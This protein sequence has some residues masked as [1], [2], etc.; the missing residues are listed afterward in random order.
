MDIDPDMNYFNT[1]I[2]NN[3]TYFLPDEFNDIDRARR[4]PYTQ[5]RFSLMHMNIV[6]VCCVTSMIL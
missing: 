2:N 4:R 5:G 1:E 6:E 3:C